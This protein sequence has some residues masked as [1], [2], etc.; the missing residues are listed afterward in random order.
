MRATALVGSAVIALGLFGGASP[1]SAEEV[2]AGP[3]DRPGPQLE[4]LGRGLIAVTAQ[5]GVHLSWRLLGHEVTGHSASGVTGADFTV[6]RDGEPIATVTDSTAYLDADGTASSEYTVVSSDGDVSDPVVPSAD[7]FLDIP[8]QRPAGGVTPPGVIHPEGEA[9]EYHANDASVADLDGDG[10]LEYLVKWDPS[11]GKDVSQVGYTGTVYLDAYELDGELLWRL[12]L[13]VNIRAGAHYTQFLAQDFDGDGKAE[14]MLKTAPGT[15][16]LPA[17]D[18]ASAQYVTMPQQDI[19]AGF[20]NE[21]DYR[22]SAEQYA[23]HLADV[24]RG[25]HEHPEVVAGRWPATIEEAIGWGEASFDYPLSEADAATLVDRFIDVYAPSRSSRNVLRQF[26]GFVISGPEY[27]TVF[28]GATGA[29]LHTEHYTPE[30]GDDGLLWGDYA[31]GRIEP[32]N[33]VDRFLAA[34]AYLDGERPSA[35]F[36]RGYYTRTNIVAYDWDGENLTQRF[37]ADSGH[38]PMSNPFDDGPHGVEGTSE[39]WGTLTTQGFH[40]LSVADV[41]SDSRQE[42][43]YGSATLDDGSLL[44]SSYDTMPEGS[45]TPGE[46]AKLGHGDAMHVGDFDPDRPGLEI[47]TVHEGGTYAPYG[48][49]MRAAEDGEI[50]FGE[51][52]GRDTG[53]GMVGDVDKK[54]PGIE[55]W[56]GNPPNQA[57]PAASGLYSA[58]GARLGDAIPGTNASIRWAGDGTTQLV[59]GGVVAADVPPSSP[60]IVRHPGRTLLTAEGTLTNNG[61]KGNPSLVADVLGDWREEL[62]V[63]TADSSA[64]RIYT[65]TEETHIKLYTLLHDPQY[66]ADVARQQTSYNQPAYPSFHLASDT[67]WSTVP[68]P[69]TAVTP[70]EVVS[71]D[72]IVTIPD[73]EGVRYLLDGEPVEAG[74]IDVRADAETA[75]SGTSGTGGVALA[76]V[77]AREVTVTAEAERWYRLAADATAS[78]TFA[79]ADTPAPGDG[80]GDGPGGGTEQDDDGASAGA[81]AGTAATGSL[82]TT[83]ADLPVPLLIGAALALLA[84]AALLIGRKM[85]GRRG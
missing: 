11:N 46:P 24:F 56:S 14:V 44:Y 64:L 37:H 27:L 77:A 66:R 21:D 17:G 47:F 80:G 62:V 54:T 19:D 69:T 50:L 75:S 45:A 65:S 34:T 31:M 43:V 29:E 40:S 67:D 74:E 63:R 83:G 76:A 41:D 32:G 15:R 10:E 58:A 48:W 85:R 60:S 28:E 3:A 7:G 38:A 30:R 22:Y 33:R 20:S 61:T 70:D 53:R 81:G 36:A 6:L 49:V 9:Y 79:I 42:I 71:A 82:S 51:Y 84:G 18:A 5:G 4:E 39:E 2:P 73:T 57:D 55:V 13:G 16:I 8:L 26:E 78:W 1:A 23:E 68:L 12:D 25:W 59:S 72:G 52:T 35:I